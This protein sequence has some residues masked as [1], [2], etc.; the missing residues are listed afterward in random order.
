MR[1]DRNRI[2]KKEFLRFLVGGGSAVLVDWLIYI[3]LLE[4]GVGNAIAKSI[5]Y[6]GGAVVGFLINKLWTFES[7]GFSYTEILKYVILYI[8]SA[9]CNASANKIVLHFIQHYAAGF[10]CATGVSTVINFTGQKFF[11]FT[12]RRC[13]K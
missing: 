3:V 10:L 7:M 13:E 2:E 12:K 6:I 5:S 4:V 11:V 1:S 9:V 8:F